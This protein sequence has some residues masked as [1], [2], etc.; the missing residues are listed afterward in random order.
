MEH[1]RSGRVLECLEGQLDVIGLDSWEFIDLPGVSSTRFILGHMTYATIDQETLEPSDTFFHKTLE[2]ASVAGD[3]ST[4][5]ADINPAL[6]IGG[7]DL[8]VQILNCSRG[9][10]GI[11]RHVNDG[12]HT[13]KSSSASTGPEAFP[14]RSTGLI[15]MHMSVHQTGEKDVR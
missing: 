14:F 11:E 4:I 3:H 13:T 5:K 9:R 8:D 2:F 12:C 15:E 1:K 7:F 10:N 6:A